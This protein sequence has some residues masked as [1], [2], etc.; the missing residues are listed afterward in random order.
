LIFERVL[1]FSGTDTYFEQG[2]LVQG[3]EPAN[4]DKGVNLP[5]IE[6]AT[7]EH[8]MLMKEVIL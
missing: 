1:S 4:C 5:D 2:L 6:L 3:V 8:D 7:P